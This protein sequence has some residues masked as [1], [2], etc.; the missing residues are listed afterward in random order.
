LI[1]LANL[2]IVSRPPLLEPP[3]SA[4]RRA[5]LTR[6]PARAPR[7]DLLAVEFDAIFDAQQTPAA[8]AAMK[9]AFAAT[10][11]RMGKVAAAAGRKTR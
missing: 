2:D 3:M 7:L 5:P 6:E 10:P 9:R 1:K 4:P 8:A 11:K